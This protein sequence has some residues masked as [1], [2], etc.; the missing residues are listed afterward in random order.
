M[1]EQTQTKREWKPGTGGLYKNSYKP[2]GD[3]KQPAMR[4]TICL[5]DGKIYRIAGWTRFNS[6][7]GEKYL[8]LRIEDEATW[9]KA[10][11]AAKAE[12]ALAQ[13]EE[14]LPF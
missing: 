4:G 3:H 2:E 7:N 11:E 1:E 5:P 8:S 12:R 14:D 9:Q 13:D 10:R 6:V